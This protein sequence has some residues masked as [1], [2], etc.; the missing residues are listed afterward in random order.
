MKYVLNNLKVEYSS[1][2][3]TLNKQFT[4]FKEQRIKADEE[5]KTFSSLNNL[6][7]NKSEKNNFKGE[8]IDSTRKLVETL[9]PKKK[10]QDEEKKAEEKKKRND[11]IKK[12]VCFSVIQSLFF[13]GLRMNAIALQDI[14]LDNIVYTSLILIASDFIT[15]FIILY[16]FEKLERKKYSLIIFMCM[17][18]ICGC[19]FIISLSTDY[20]KTRVIN[21]ILAFLFKAFML[22][23]MI[24]T[25][26]FTSTL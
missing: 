12:L 24:M 6:S 14:G 3:Q 23:G 10:E 8:S 20:T 1:R 11:Y 26:L 9:V 17:S 13:I 19:L 18:I 21:L 7:D 25:L 2:K 5:Y 15:N 16:F 4:L 22:L